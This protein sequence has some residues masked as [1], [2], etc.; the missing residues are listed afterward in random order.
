MIHLSL[1]ALLMNLHFFLDQCS[2][3]SFII[4]FLF[5]IFPISADLL[6]QIASSVSVFVICTF[7]QAATSISAA[8]APKC[9]VQPYHCES[10][11]FG[12]VCCEACFSP[13]QLRRTIWSLM[14]LQYNIEKILSTSLG[15]LSFAG[16]HQNTRISETMPIFAHHINF[17]T[18]REWVSQWLNVFERNVSAPLHSAVCS[19]PE[20]VFSTK[21][22]CIKVALISPQPMEN[23]VMLS[24]QFLFQG[25][26]QE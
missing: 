17:S 13:C 2:L 7:P 26:G 19:L 25:T 20:E 16:W 18:I 4:L 6:S 1:Q 10:Q 11:F 3:P 5:L 24:C 9:V 23:K 8:P 21:R 15:L 22:H 12:Y 14:T